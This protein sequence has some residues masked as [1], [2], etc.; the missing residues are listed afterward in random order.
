[1][2]NRLYTR[3]NQIL[4]D[5]V[6]CAAA[7]CLAF[8]LRYGTGMPAVARRQMLWLLPVAITQ[9]LVSAFWGNHRRAWRYVSTQDAV[10]LA[11]AYVVCAG[12][13]IAA[14]LAIGP[15]VPLLH[16]PVD[17][18]VTMCLLTIVG[19]IGLRVTR[20]IFYEND[21]DR[22]TAI[23]T[24]GPQRFLIIGAGMHGITVAREMLLRKGIE[25]VGFL[26]DDPEKQ[27]FT[28][29][30]VPVLGFISDLGQVAQSGRVD[31]ILVCISPQSR[32]YLHLDNVRTS[33]GLPLPS[34]IVPTLEEILQGKHESA[35]KSL[36]HE[37][38]SIRVPESI[39]AHNE[40]ASPKS[41]GDNNGHK[42]LLA[43]A[44]SVETL[45]RLQPP[46]GQKARASIICTE[47][48]PAPQVRNKT[49]LITGGAGFIGSSVA[50]R[51]VDHNNVILFDISFANSP[52]QYTSLLKHPNVTCLEGNILHADL[53]GLMKQADVVIHAAA[54]LGVDRVCKSARETL[55]T[56]YVGTSRLLRA[57][58]EKHDIQRFI[59]FSTSEVFGVNSFRVDEAS[60]PHIGP[61]AESRWSYAMSKLAGEHLVASYFRE[62]RL[63][64]A[65]VRPFNV[66]GPR[67]VGDYAL[68]RFISKALHNEPLEV[69]GDGTQIRSWC[70]I[71]DFCSALV[72]MVAR[73]EAIGEDF[74]IGSPANI[75]TVHDLA[76]KVIQ[77]TGSRSQ[78]V[79]RKA[80]FPDISIRVPSP[81][82][83]KRL[84]GYEPKVDL[85]TGLRLTIEWHKKN[86]DT[87]SPRNPMPVLPEASAREQVTA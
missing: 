17:V 62:T 31:E 83:A 19:A 55:E 58:D 14:A 37:V 85:D 29:A 6:N 51:F 72:Q 69:H 54:M 46:N 77:L 32:Q 44:S 24:D 42:G 57:L 13:F 61:I 26:D 16:V 50:Q 28:I 5:A 3:Q 10:S 47:A 73:P 71:E 34:R 33:Q 66:F 78:V 43:G 8:L 2:S 45:K 18:L 65:I 87:L 70:F 84:L 68:K 75:A 11:R 9:C 79:F 80:P 86:L 81:D 63:P 76:R 48:G 40:A 1:M 35:G 38:S 27:G 7:W 60:Q 56:N 67:R 15:Y 23:N 74:N 4:L 39:V 25:V 22:P 12:V 64:I 53:A 52:A 30:G 49:I 20:R 21:Y 41:N 36:A 59:Y 82:K